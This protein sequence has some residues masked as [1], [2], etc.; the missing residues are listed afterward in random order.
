VMMPKS[1]ANDSRNLN[2]ISIPF[3]IA[4]ACAVSSVFCFMISS[5]RAVNQA[6]AALAHGL[7]APGWSWASFNTSRSHLM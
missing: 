6:P 4:T 3:Y 7:L 1:R 2:F 5:A